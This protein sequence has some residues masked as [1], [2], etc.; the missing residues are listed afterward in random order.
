MV[1][2]V[3][4]TSRPDHLGT[5]TAALLPVEPQPLKLA[6]CLA[7]EDPRASSQLP[8]SPSGKL[9]QTVKLRPSSA[10]HFV[11][12]MLKMQGELG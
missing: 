12:R 11:F 4:P 8:S 6:I 10:G 3:G 1:E 5:G 7:L 9:W 2:V